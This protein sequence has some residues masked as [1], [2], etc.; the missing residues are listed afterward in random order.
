M[1]IAEK[2]FKVKVS[3]KG[4]IVIPKNIRDVYKIQEGDVVLMIPKE[5]GLLIKRYEVKEG[6]MRGLLKD[7]GVDIEECEAILEE[8]KKMITKARA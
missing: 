8:A 2:L 3:A 4:Q 6:S 5:E 1:K 7:L